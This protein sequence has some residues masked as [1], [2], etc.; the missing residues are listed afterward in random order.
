MLDV[1]Q[2]L[3]NYT[4]KGVVDGKATGETFLGKVN[5]D[6]YLNIDSGKILLPN[7][8]Y[9]EESSSITQPLTTTLSHM[10]I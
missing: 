5:T 3:D 2:L 10:A 1:I 9:G 6:I 8:R 4:A 7:A